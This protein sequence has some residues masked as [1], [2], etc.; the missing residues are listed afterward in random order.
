MSTP[1]EAVHILRD[2]NGTP[3][4]A[5]LPFAQY[6]AL[7][8]KQDTGIPADVAEKAVLH[9]ISA[10]RA[11]RE[12]LGITQEAVARKLGMAQSSY[13]ELENRKTIRKSSREKI[14]NALGI[15]PEQLD[16]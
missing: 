9:D 2:T 5:V 8:G 3:I 15:L 12:Y 13:S 10:A 6:Q 1:T 7:T 16:F 14:A 11:W 4:F